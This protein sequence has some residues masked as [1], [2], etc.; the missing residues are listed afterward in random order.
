MSQDQ[1]YRRFR[2]VTPSGDKKWISEYDIEG[3]EL[4][5]LTQ[6][7]PEVLYSLRLDLSI[8]RNV[9]S[10][11]LEI[12]VPG[13]G[14][15]IFGYSSS[16]AF[17][18]ST[19][20]GIEVSEP[21]VFVVARV[22]V[23]L[24]SN[25]FHMKHNR[26]FRGTFNKLYLGWPAQANMEARLVIFK[27]D[28]EPYNT[29][30]Y[31]NRFNS[32]EASNVDSANAAVT[33]SSTASAIVAESLSRKCATITNP[34]TETI[35]IFLGDSGVT[36][37]AGTPLAPGERCFWRNTAALYGITSSTSNTNIRVLEEF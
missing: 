16:S 9:N 17:T 29:N 18:A 1:Y 11:P 15:T 3:A 7:N 25:S 4:Q 32:V 14:V 31:D 19:N 22:N 35:T 33:V 6:Q 13:R 34:G 20:T 5:N 24:P 21:A 37:A 30:E 26:G 27:A 36:A 10:D 28:L 12:N 2:Q 8:A 23:N